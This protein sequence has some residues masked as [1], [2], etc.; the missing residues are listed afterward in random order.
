[1]K[2]L[3]LPAAVAL[4]T[5]SMAYCAPLMATQY[6]VS[7]TATFGTTGG[8]VPTGSQFGDSSYAPTT[9]ILSDGK[10]TF[11][12]AT[13]TT[14]TGAGD[15]TVTYQ[16]FQTNTATAAVDAFGNAAFTTV[17]LKFHISAV[18]LDGAPTGVGNNCDF[19]PIVL[20]S[21]DGSADA[22]GMSVSQS[23]VTI[24]QTTGACGSFTPVINNLVAGGTAAVDLTLDGD[25]LRWIFA[26]GF[27][28]P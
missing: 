12:Q 21:L 23:G 17:N 6:P 4:L 27:E 19:G 5:A 1:M 2:I 25:F 18:T 24:P 20:D 28:G 9:G 11:P 15:V 7:G 13:F 14:T 10:F 8:A 16:V 26:D 22:N 3:H